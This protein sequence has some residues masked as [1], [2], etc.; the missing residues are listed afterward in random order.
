MAWVQNIW[1]FISGLNWNI[2]IMVPFFLYLLWPVV[3]PVFVYCRF[4]QIHFPFII[5]LQ[6][7]S[8]LMSRMMRVLIPYRF[9]HS[10]I[11]MLMLFVCIFW[12]AFGSLHVNVF[13]CRM[14]LFSSIPMLKSESRTS[15]VLL[16]P[17]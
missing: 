2:C 3:K 7:G 9:Q 5:V 14:I 10:T 17:K 1:F 16:L 4:S 6:T 15:L 13:N 11:K 12:L 8:I